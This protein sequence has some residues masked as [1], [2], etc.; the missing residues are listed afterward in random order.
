MVLV[1]EG[2]DDDLAMPSQNGMPQ[3]DNVSLISQTLVAV[4]AKLNQLIIAIIDFHE[5]VYVLSANFSLSHDLSF[6]ACVV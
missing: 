2:P 5:I 4:T 3:N 6:S 1:R